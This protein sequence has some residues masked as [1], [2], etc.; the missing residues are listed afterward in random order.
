MNRGARDTPGASS[1]C[2]AMCP[3]DPFSCDAFG[4]DFQVSAYESV[5][6]LYDYFIGRMPN[7]SLSWNESLGTVTEELV[8]TSENHHILP[9]A[10][11]S[12]LSNQN[13]LVFSD[14]RNLFKPMVFEVNA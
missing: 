6:V 2:A 7:K 11:L 1:D 12:F 13:F 8:K 4:M 14:C 10:F 5:S 3:I 9:T